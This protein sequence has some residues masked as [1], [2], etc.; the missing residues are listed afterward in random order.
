MD[1]RRAQKNND[2]HMNWRDIMSTRIGYWRSNEGSTKMELT[3]QNWAQKKKKKC[4]R[5][6]QSLVISV[7]QASLIWTDL[8]AF[9]YWVHSL[10]AAAS[11][12]SWSIIWNMW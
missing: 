2:E 6:L 4:F 10:Y 11:I 12:Y 5:W 8:H 1:E 3:G 7:A 9:Q